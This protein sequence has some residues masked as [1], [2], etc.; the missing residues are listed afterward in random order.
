MYAVIM[1]FDSLREIETS[2]LAEVRK[3]HHVGIMTVPRRSTLSGAFVRISGLFL[4]SLPSC[5]LWIE[6]IPV[7]RVCCVL[8]WQFGIK[9]VAAIPDDNTAV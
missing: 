2:M 6:A 4:L 3:L 8:Y 5:V 9:P 7:Q 1:R